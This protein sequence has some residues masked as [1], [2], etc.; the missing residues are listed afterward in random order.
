MSRD[1]CNYLI[2]S[3]KAATGAGTNVNVKGFRHVVL[4]IVGA[5]SPN[6]TVKIQ[7]SIENSNV[8]PAFGSAQSVT[9]IWDYIQGIDLQDGAEID[10][11]TGIS[12]T[13]SNDVRIIEVNTN[14]LDWINVNVTAYAAGKI[15]VLCRGYN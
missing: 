3:E 2:H 14:G 7:G 6:A 1:Y 15:T 9:N 13:G 5:S 4:A 11:D 10:G 8:G 12:F